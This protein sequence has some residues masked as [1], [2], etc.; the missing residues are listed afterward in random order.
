MIL[1]SAF[2]SVPFPLPSTPFM[3]T[4]NSRAFQETAPSWQTSL[5][6]SHSVRGPRHRL[7]SGC[8]SSASPMIPAHAV[9]AETLPQVQLVGVAVAAARVE[10]DALDE[11]TPVRVAQP[12]Q[13]EYVLNACSPFLST[14][15]LTVRFSHILWKSREVQA[16]IKPPLQERVGVRLIEHDLPGLADDHVSI[17]EFSNESADQICILGG[18]SGS[19]RGLAELVCLRRWVSETGNSPSITRPP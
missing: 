2:A 12:K 8:A 10:D 15:V 3:T 19:S 1:R 6:R 11:L 4:L 17:V 7:H 5:S 9:P 18:L 13:G 14:P 16:L